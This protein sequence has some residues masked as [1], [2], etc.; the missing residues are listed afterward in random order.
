MDNL[1]SIFFGLSLRFIVTLVTTPDSSLNPDPPSK[2]IS[3]VKLIG[4]LVGLWEGIVLLHFT[5]KYPRSY[6]PYVAYAVRMF[7]DLL[8]TE[9][10]QRMML[11][12]LWTGLG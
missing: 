11:V 6:D 1:F 8:V 3:S 9:D 10:M 4:S 12:L 5:Q 2:Y 7:V